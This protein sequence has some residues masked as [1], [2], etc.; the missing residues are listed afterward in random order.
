MILNMI[1]GLYFFPIFL[2]ARAFVSVQI[3]R[4]TI[5]SPSSSCSFIHN[6]SFS[7]NPSIQSCIWQ[8]VNTDNCQTGVYFDRANVCSMYSELCDI[9]RLQPSGAIRADVICYRKNQSKLILLKL[10]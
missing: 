5:Y 8:C 10:R 7:D 4:N 9:N 6:V 2:T 1:N 3:H